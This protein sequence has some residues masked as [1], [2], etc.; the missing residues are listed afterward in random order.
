VTSSADDPR[1]DGPARDTWDPD[2][3]HRYRTERRRPFD[4][5]VA[6][7]EPIPGGT[8]VDL[9]C[10][11]GELTAAAAEALG[12]SG[13]VGIDASPAMLDQAR[14]VAAP[15]VDLT[16]RRGD[17]AA[18]DEPASW[19]VVLANASLHWVPDHAAVLAR[20]RRSLRA[21]GQLAV[22]VPANPDHPSHTTITEVLAE[23]PFASLVP[24]PP[25]D[26]LHSVLDPA[27]YAE[28]LWEL[29]ARDPLVRLEV[30][31]M[32]L[33]STAEVV[34]WTSGTALTRVRRLVDEATY[35]RFVD[36]YRE[37]LVQRLG[38][39]SPYYYAFKRILMVA[40]FP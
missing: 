18:F 19:D 25:P 34:E 30:F 26:P 31:G 32:E 39:R 36:R 27:R 6:L 20:W 13:A 40:R 10:G 12:V 22:G 21:G 5:L 11:T 7:L 4:Q 8:L 2:R 23:E 3:Y 1:T 9:G 33:S 29:G 16:F 15:G 14:D 28:I 35:E 38:D 17:L 37:R 24:D